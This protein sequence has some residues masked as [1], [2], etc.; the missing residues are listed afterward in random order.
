MQTR[1]SPCISNRRVWW[2]ITA[3]TRPGW[4]LIRL[5]SPSHRHQPGPSTQWGGGGANGAP[6]TH[7]GPHPPIQQPHTATIQPYPPSRPVQEGQCA[8]GDACPHAHSDWEYHLH[9]S[10]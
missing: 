9:E 1:A 8:L 4:G 2:Y 3:T 7:P 6:H 10:S 5:Y